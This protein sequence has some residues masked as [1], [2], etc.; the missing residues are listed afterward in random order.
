MQGRRKN[1]K[2]REREMIYL[3]KKADR[4]Q[5]FDVDVQLTY[6]HCKKRGG[7]RKKPSSVRHYQPLEI[8]F[9]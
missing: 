5:Q 2:E 7:E 1:E 4:Q 8:F 6:N 3:T 9:A